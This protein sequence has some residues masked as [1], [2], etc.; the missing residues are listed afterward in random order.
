MKL[1]MMNPFCEGP[2]ERQ[3]PSGIPRSLLFH[4][5]RRFGMS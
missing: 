1:S 2:T 4:S 5:I 3:K